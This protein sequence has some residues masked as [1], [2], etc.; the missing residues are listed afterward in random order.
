MSETAAE[1]IAAGKFTAG[2]GSL[3]AFL[4]WG[5]LALVP[6]LGLYRFWVLTRKRQ[7]YWMN[8]VIGGH[9]L[10][11]TGTPIEVMRGFLAIVALFLPAYALSIVI[12]LQ[13][14]LLRYAGLGVLFALFW[15]F[16][17]FAIYRGRGYRLSHTFWRGIRFGQTGSAWRYATR[18]FLWSLVMLPT[19]GLVYPL[20]VADLWRYRWTNTFYGDKPFSFTGTWKTVAGAF[21]RAYAFGV[22]P[23][24]ILLLLG[25][26]RTYGILGWSP[27]L[28]LPLV[29]ALSFLAAL[30]AVAA[31]PYFRSREISSCYS[32]VRLGEARA[33]VHIGARRLFGQYF[34]FGILA[35]ITISVVYALA[36]A[37]V[38]GAGAEVGSRVWV[39]SALPLLFL[40]LFAFWM[41]LIVDF[42]F[43]S[44][45]AAG[46][47]FTGLA[48]LIDAQQRPDD[49]DARGEG[50]ADALNIGAF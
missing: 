48:T 3:F 41:E 39:F 46:T 6:S 18:R 32:A 22:A 45:L 35:A 9:P 14:T 49:A 50:L 17:G 10:E 27:N 15:Y 34:T 8:T 24:G 23:L 21:Y 36:S 47:R 5:Y 25:F 29:S 44:R 11:Y 42:G 33:F 19:L 2:R 43:W 13:D 12:A 38:F 1:P 28:P 30:A 7:F 20:M 16:S 31:F 40:T 26:A 37:Y 4:F